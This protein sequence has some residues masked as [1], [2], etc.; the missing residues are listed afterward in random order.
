MALLGRRRPGLIPW[1][2][3]INGSFSVVSSILVMMVALAWGFR[4][5]FIIAAAVY[6][7]AWLALTRLCRDI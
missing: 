1:A 7:C 4:A 6:A 2:W 3:C 5:A